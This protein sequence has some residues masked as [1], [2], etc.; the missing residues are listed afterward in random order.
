[1]ES[2][3]VKNIFLNHFFKT[4]TVCLTGF[5]QFIEFLLLGNV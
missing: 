4:K 2:E 3:D 5:K 1:M